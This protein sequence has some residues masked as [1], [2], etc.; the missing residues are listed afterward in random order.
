[1]TTET[2]IRTL[3]LAD[4]ALQEFFGNEENGTFRMFDRELQPNYLKVGQTCA[5]FRRISTVRTYFHSTDT[6]RSQNRLAMPRFQFDVLDYSAERARSAAA[7][8][9]DWFAR[10]D[11]ASNSMFDSPP[12]SPRQHPNQVLNH[13]S[14]SITKT[15]PT[16]WVEMLDVRII[17]LEEE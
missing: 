9:I 11:F 13:L 3:A 4:A 15:Q 1:V 6:Q 12:T 17:D 16:I 8:L 14:R 7:A 5:T 2:K 10:V